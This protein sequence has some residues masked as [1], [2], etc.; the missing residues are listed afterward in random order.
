MYGGGSK[1]FSSFRKRAS[2]ARDPIFHTNARQ[3]NQ[4]RFARSWTPTRAAGRQRRVTPGRSDPRLRGRRRY[5]RRIPGSKSQPGRRNSYV[6]ST[7]SQTDTK[8]TLTDTRSN[9]RE[10]Q[11]AGNVVNS[12]SKSQPGQFLQCSCKSPRALLRAPGA[13]R[14]SVACPCRG[15]TSSIQCQA[16]KRLRRRSSKRARR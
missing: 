6:I 7:R 2:A 3:C 11:T 15:A 14:P 5:T 1:D 13:L 12:C 9:S 10:T 8:S 4:A 16:G